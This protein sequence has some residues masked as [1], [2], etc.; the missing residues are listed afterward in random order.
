[1]PRIALV[2]TIILVQSLCQFCIQKEN[3]GADFVLSQ[4]VVTPPDLYY[5]SS[6]NACVLTS[7]ANGSSVCFHV[8]PKNCNLEFFNNIANAAILQ[9][10]KDDLT[11]ISINYSSCSSGVS[12]LF[13]KYNAMTPPASMALQNAAG[14]NGENLRSEIVLYSGSSCA[15]LGLEKSP[16]VS[17]S[18]SRAI[19]DSELASLN[20]VTID[21][22]VITA[23]SSQCISDLSIKP[24]YMSLINGIR[25]GSLALAITCS[26]AGG[27]FPKCP[28][29]P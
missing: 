1:M 15:D 3:P 12:A 18:F 20:S 4:I 2:F 7:Q 17:A 11:F 23:T 6:Q 28:W 13:G 5:T 26:S 14:W 19:N 27:S 25:N 8:Q 16:F 10:R 21:L 9:N 24:E 29:L 22:A